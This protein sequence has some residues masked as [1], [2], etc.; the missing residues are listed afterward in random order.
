VCTPQ[1]LL[2]RR[3]VRLSSNQVVNS[4][5]TLAG[6]ELAESIA[7]AESLPAPNARAFPPL[8]LEGPI[9]T[10]PLFS[11]GDRVAETVGKRVLD[12]F[13]AITGC[14]ST[15]T[16][17]C[18]R[19]FVTSFAERAYRRPLADAE[20]E[21]LLTAYADFTTAGATVPEAVQHGVWAV[22]DSPYFLYR[23]EFGAEATTPEVVLAPYEMASQLS[24]F[25]TD[26]PPDEELLSAASRD[27][28]AS[29]GDVAAHARRLLQSEPARANL[30]AAMASY[31][32]LARVPSTVLEP[33]AVPGF[34]VTNDLLNSMVREGELF[35]EHTLFDAPLGALLTSRRAY[36][37]EPL[38]ALYRVSLPTAGLDADGFGEVELAEDR[39][40]LLTS[41]PFLTSRARPT[42]T[43][44][45][46]RGLAVN[47]LILCQ[48]SP[49]FRG[50][51]D[52]PLT[53]PQDSWTER[54]KAE[55]RATTAPCADCHSLFDAFGVA[56][57]SFD[58][59]G[60]FRSSDLESRPID[61]AVTLPAI[62]D[63]R[64]V[65][66]AAEMAQLL[67][68]SDGFRACMARSY[69]DYALAEAAD[70]GIDPTN[71]SLNGCEL[72]T[73]VDAFEAA[74]DPSFAGLVTEIA[75][76][77]L[78]RLREGEPQ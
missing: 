68:D 67:A 58:A 49:P 9:V 32:S 56:L 63:G 12:D 76:S 65:S 37:N 70:R 69:S 6:S 61:T 38:A 64:A 14:G 35:F 34:T 30:V 2:P 33:S 8:G 50:D 53:E 11:F 16:D 3:L 41:A 36:V 47:A 31:F 22:L 18:G 44:V 78:L 45:V 39:A 40:G 25:L 52:H 59:V 73:I 72:R 29:T 71:T 66:G 42:G 48:Q 75:R 62:L 77:R 54:Q 57:D 13:A 51:E 5:G 21:S 46:A 55:Y 26:T 10:E 23:T 17:E 24:Y 60:R 43:S 4:I 20:R 27:E 7:A 74:G 1:P 19:N 15:P 28:L